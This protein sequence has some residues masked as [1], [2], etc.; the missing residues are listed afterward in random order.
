MAYF[1]GQI[2]GFLIISSI[3]YFPFIRPLTRL[4]KG[5]IILKGPFSEN[6]LAKHKGF[7]VLITLYH[8]ALSLF[9]F[10]FSIIG[11]YQTFKNL[12]ESNNYGYYYLVIAILGTVVFCIG[13]TLFYLL[14]K[15]NNSENILKLSFILPVH[16]LVFIFWSFFLGGHLFYNQNQKLYGGIMLSMILVEIIYLITLY[17]FQKQIGV[18]WKKL[19]NELIENKE[20]D[21]TTDKNRT[22][23]K[24]T[25]NVS[26]LDVD[27]ITQKSKSFQLNTVKSQVIEKTTGFK[28]TKF[29]QPDFHN[30]I[31]WVM[32]I[33]LAILFLA[34]LVNNYIWAFV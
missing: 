22:F 20:I 31:Y 19:K 11:T 10:I 14:N 18:T 13:I 1:I 21:I 24:N 26:P 32:S 17:K 6:N 29:Q 15:K 3:I 12:D 27:I 25:I 8:L 4:N 16:S 7:S 33:L 2:L 34:L 9:T 30:T 28:P 5:N 23:E